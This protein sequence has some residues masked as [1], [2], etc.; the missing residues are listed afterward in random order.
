MF[1]LDN[2][3]QS[4]GTTL[5]E[6]LIGGAG[7]QFFFCSFSLMIKERTHLLERVCLILC[8]D[9]RDYLWLLTWEMISRR[10]LKKD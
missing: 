6:G 5:G 4:D 1:I 3:R 9:Q 2:I 7:N 8:L 10:Q